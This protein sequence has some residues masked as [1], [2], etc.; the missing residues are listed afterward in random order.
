[1]LAFAA[2]LLLVPATQAF[3]NETLKVEIEGSGW[4]KVIPFG[5]SYQGTPPVNCVYVPPGPATGECE[6]QMSD[7][8]AGYEQVFM[9]AV[10]DPG[11]EFVEWKI[12]EGTSEQCNQATGS[13]PKGEVCAPY[14]EPSG[15]GGAKVTAVFKATHEILQVN[16]EG[17]G[18]G[19]VIPFGA[20]Y[21]GTP[22]I[23]CAYTPPGPP[24]GACR[25]QMSDE[26]AGYEQVFMKAVPAPGSGSEFVEWKIEEGTYEQCNQATG[27]FPKGEVCAPYSEPSGSGGAEVTAVFA[28]NGAATFPM[29]TSETGAGDGTTEVE[30]KV[31]A[32]FVPCSGPLADGTEVKVVATAGS[33]SSLVGLTGT[34]SA[35]LHCSIGTASEGSCVFTITEASSVTAEFE[36]GF[37]L[38]V[39]KSGRGTGMVV[40]LPA[41]INCGDLCQAI[42]PTG[43]EVSL[44]PSSDSG[45]G[46]EG[47]SGCDSVQGDVCLL[48]MDA[49]HVVNAEFGAQPSITN[50]QATEVGSSSAVL[51]AEVNPEE[52][53]TSYYFEYISL[54]DYEANGN[55][56]EGA[57][58]AT[59]APAVPVAIG[60]G[61]TPVAVAVKV[62]GLQSATAYRFR[63]VATSAIGTAEGPVASF[64]THATV[65]DFTGQCPG[66]ESL[67]TGPGANLPDC[68]AYEQVSPVNKNG[69]SLQGKAPITRAASDGSAIS[70]EAPGGIPGGNG[71]QNFPSYVGKRGSGSWVTS[72]LLPSALSGQ[73]AEWLGWTPDFSEVFDEVNMF[74]QGTALVAKD[75]ASGAETT[76]APYTTPSPLYSYVDSSADGAA[77]VFEAS[78]KSYTTLK[79]TPN[80][81]AGKPNVYA[82]NRNAPG[83]IRLAGVLPDGSTPAEGSAA[84]AEATDYVRDTNRVSVDGS[85]FFEDLQTGLLYQRLNPTAPE[86]TEKNEGVCVPDPVFACTV[87]VSASQKANGQGIDGHDNA[88]RSPAAFM[89]ASEDGTK[90]L[91]LSSEKLTDDATTGPEPGV[92]A[93]ARAEKSNGSDMQLSFMPT[94]AHEIAIDEAAEYVYWTDPAADRIGRAKLDGTDF[95]ADFITGLD[96]PQGI[97]VIDQGSSTYVFWTQRGALDGQG[98]AQTDLG[99]IGRADLDGTNVNPSCI[100]G[101]TNPR[102]IAADSNFIYWTMPE[103]AQPYLGTIG[104]TELS[105]AGSV[106]TDLSEGNVADLSGDIAVDA[107]HIY[108]SSSTNTFS[109]SFIY[110]LELDGSGEAFHGNFPIKVEGTDSAL[111][112]AVDGTNLYWSNSATNEIGR[113]DLD[114]A[115][116]KFDF[117]T[118]SAHPEDL[119]LAGSHLYWVA[120]QGGGTSNPGSDLYRY[121]RDSGKLIDLTVDHADQNGA[122][123]QGVLGA[124]KDASVVYFVAN[125]VLDG[126][127]NSPNEN[128]EIAEPGDCEGRNQLHDADCNLYVSHDGMVDFIARLHEGRVFN[129]ESPNEEFNEYGSGDLENWVR[130]RGEMGKLED[131]KTARVSDDGKVLVFRSV[132]LLTGYD[133]KGPCGLS[134]GGLQVPGRCAEFYRFNY[135]D[136]RLACLTC[137]PRGQAPIGPARIASIRPVGIGGAT[138]RTSVLARNLSADGSR[139][140]FESPDALVAGDTNGQDGCPAWGG[141]AQVSSSRSCQDVYEW[142]APGMGSCTESSPAFTASSGGCVYLISTGKS[143]EASFFADAD[144]KGENAFFFTYDR[145]V[146]Q[147]E[148]GLM[149]VYDARVGGGLADQYPAKPGSCSGEACKPLPPPASPGQSNGTASFSGPGNPPHAKTKKKKH[150]K[151]QH[152]KKK[153]KGKKGRA[154]KANGRMGR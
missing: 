71:A 13:F 55:S 25:V 47:W 132:N 49:D 128:G 118:E 64:T 60:A 103:I 98:R 35:A 136:K 51:R 150:H 154:A 72:G 20:S 146:G 18:R 145:L 102:S 137:D 81:A 65:Q 6:V 147:D 38:E 8:G 142:E 4:G 93:I 153:G 78:D 29:T 33:A 86:T 17:T 109:N 99:T 100:T 104:R 27:S 50:T 62:E 121:D 116:A 105:C 141:G 125:G 73:A 11:S 28:S 90:A 3:A 134:G 44:T 40:G 123:V 108:V 107:N 36:P 23:N 19:N 112:L 79:L 43:T 5:A 52:Q 101:I 66:N 41:G 117:I 83:I 87:E 54:A 37:S 48:T 106:E 115:N 67:R 127:G 45:S 58:A 9:K 57:H 96:E 85:V 34:G 120:N 143:K 63:A 89:A 16:I 68:R 69:G 82:W 140:F 144:E 24:T 32:G 95:K 92:P 70:F 76:I 42:F 10:P 46:F 26:G 94:P 53:A 14:S 151:K 119:A 152:H 139:F 61:D 80:A 148:D 59:K 97:A 133:N 56:F 1:L 113:S 149:D 124:S 138:P 21:R 75:T 12:E 129:A 7:E 74:G 84:G 77:V 15:S 30:C 131:D 91:F 122:E 126:V 88:G 130:N 111:G 110:Q 135:E 2:A 31:G 22:S 39:G 114:G